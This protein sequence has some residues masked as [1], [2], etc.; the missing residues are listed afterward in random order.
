MLDLLDRK[1]LLKS[2]PHG[3]VGAE[4]G[5]RDGHFS[6]VILAVNRPRELWLVDI[7]KH[8]STEVYGKDKSNVSD[9]AQERRFQAVTEKFANRPHVKILREWSDAAA[10]NFPDEYFDWWFLDANHSLVD[11][12]ITAWW[13][14][15]KSGGWAT[16][17][18]FCEPDVADYI[19]TKPQVEAFAAE[20]GLEIHVAGLE[21]D[22]PMERRYPSWAIRKPLA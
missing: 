3:G 20:R 14:K 17:H 2:I 9:A 21:S 18:D 13:P 15:L 8:Q 7:W 11:K 4:I 6:E 22:N 19:K 10:V 5:V 12:D 16:G 1:S